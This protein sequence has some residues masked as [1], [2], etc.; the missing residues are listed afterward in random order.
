MPSIK[1]GYYPS[2][3]KIVS[4]DQ[5]FGFANQLRSMQ[6][7]YYDPALGRFLSIDPVGFSPDQ[8]FMFG[9]YTYV[10]NDPINAWDPKGGLQT[11]QEHE[12]AQQREVFVVETRQVL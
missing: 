6:A 7:R 4:L 11:A 5:F 3:F 1:G 12:S 9:R 8:P 10:A 2:S